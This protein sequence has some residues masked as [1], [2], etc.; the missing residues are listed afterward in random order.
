MQ[1]TS[2]S[3][4]VVVILTTALVITTIV[5]VVLSVTRN[6]SQYGN[7]TSTAA[8][9]QQ[10]GIAASDEVQAQT[11]EQQEQASAAADV[12]LDVPDLANPDDLRALNAFLSN[13]TESNCGMETGVKGHRAFDRDTSSGQ[14]HAGL[15]FV[16][17]AQEGG[18]LEDVGYDESNPWLGNVRVSADHLDGMLY[19]LCG[20]T[21]DWPGLEEPQYVGYRYVDGYVY[22]EV[23]NWVGLYGPAVACTVRSEDDGTI[24]VDYAGYYQTTMQYPQ[25][26]DDGTQY[27]LNEEQLVARYG[28]VPNGRGTARLECSRTDGEWDFRLIRLEASVDE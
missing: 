12:S 15:A 10:A 5:V 4:L 21:F 6:G 9:E 19:R 25:L 22:T 7:E 8:T 16:R 20:R 17:F 24:T 18:K 3:R 14:L 13:F 1:R 11:A 2:T 28:L 27:G 26:Q 23:T